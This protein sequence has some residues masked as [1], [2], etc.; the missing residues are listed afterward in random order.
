MWHGSCSTATCRPVA[1]ISTRPRGNDARDDHD[2][3][4]SRWQEDK[5]HE[6]LKLDESSTQNGRVAGTVA[7]K[8]QE[9]LG[10][11]SLSTARRTR[12]RTRTR[13]SQTRTPNAHSHATRGRQDHIGTTT[14][15]EKAHVAGED[16]SES[17]CRDTTCGDERLEQ[18]S[19]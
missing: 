7:V 2:L 3:K 15:R 17:S 1:P 11:A 8:R 4:T 9:Q 14:L 12:F 5:V 19:S 18:G 6:T 16:D 10:P 13:S